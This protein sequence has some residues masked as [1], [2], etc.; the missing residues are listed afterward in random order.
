[1]SQ[2]GKKKRQLGNRLASKEKWDSTRE[3]R[4]SLNLPSAPKNL[5][6][7]LRTEQ[8]MRIRKRIE[9]QIRKRE[10][11]CIALSSAAQEA[12]VKSAALRARQTQVHILLPLLT[13]SVTLDSWVQLNKHLPSTCL[14]PGNLPGAEHPPGNSRCQKPPLFWRL[15]SDEGLLPHGE[16]RPGEER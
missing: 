14:M 13:G 10:S 16:K 2:R 15:S 3:C 4:Q 1:M 7:Y 5:G 9:L 6:N 12:V 8:V 11:W